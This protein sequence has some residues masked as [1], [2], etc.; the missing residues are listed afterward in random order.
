M[1]SGREGSDG[2]KWGLGPVTKSR[3]VV[4]SWTG[5]VSVR[6]VGRTGIGVG[7]DWD[8]DLD[9]GVVGGNV[10]VEAEG[11]D[12]SLVLITDGRVGLAEDWDRSTDPV[13]TESTD[14]G[15]S[16][17]CLPDVGQRMGL[18]RSVMSGRG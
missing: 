14:A 12:D 18:S 8:L 16:E 3:G 1:F 7:G 9:L 2:G 17:S 5:S 6:S 15:L 10:G 11:A 4:I 13:V